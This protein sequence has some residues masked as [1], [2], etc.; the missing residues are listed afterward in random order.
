M[1]KLSIIVAVALGSLVACSM[2]I[3]QDSGKRDAKKGFRGGPSV[4]QLKKDLDLKDDQVPKVKAALEER[5][6]KMQELRGDT[7]L[8]QQQ[9]R[10]KMRGLMEESNK[11][12]KGILTEEQYKKYQER[13]RAAAKKGGEKKSGERKG[14]KKTE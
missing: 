12:M 14:K 2:A 11:K 9:R 7:A 13:G 1:K 8:D 4:E 3:A 5:Q 10:E 6:K